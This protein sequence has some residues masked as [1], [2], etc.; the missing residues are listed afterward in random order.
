MSNPETSGWQANSIVPLTYDGVDWFKA[1][2]YNSNTTYNNAL[3]GQGYGVCETAT[4][5]SA[6]VATV[7]GYTKADGGIVTIK[8][9]Q[10]VNANATLN[11]NSLGASP[12]Y[13]RGV[14]IG[15]DAIRAGDTAYFIYN[16]SIYHLL[17]IDRWEGTTYTAGNGIYISPSNQ[18]INEG[19]VAIGQGAENGTIG[20][21]IGNNSSNVAVKGLR[22]LAFQDAI[23]LATTATAG[24]VKVGSGIT[25][26]S[27]GTISM[28][29]IEGNV[30]GDGTSGHLTKFTADNIIGDGPALS[31]AIQTQTTSTKFLREDGTWSVPSYTE[32]T[33]SLVEQKN[34][35]ANAEYRV[36]LSSTANNAN[37]IDIVNKSGGLTFNPHENTLTVA[38][39]N[40]KATAAAEADHAS[41]AAYAASALNATNAENATNAV[42]AQHAATA[43][44]AATAN[45]TKG[46]LS[47]GGKSFNGSTSVSV[48]AADLGISGAMHFLGISSTALIDGS[49]ASSIVVSGNTITPQNGDVVLYNSGEY[50][51]TGTLWELLGDES[52]YKIKQTAVLNPT[53][54]STNSYTF[55]QSITQDEQGVIT[56]VR[57]TVP[58]A[59]TNVAGIVTTGAQTFA[60]AKTFT[61][62][63]TATTFSGYL[64]GT[65]SNALSANYANSA[66]NANTVNNHTV[67]S[68]VPANAVFTDTWVANSVSTAGYVT[69]PGTSNKNKV[70]KTNDSGVPGWRDD[71]NTEY[72]V[73]TATEA[74]GGTATTGRVVT[75]ALLK[76]LSVASAETAGYAACADYA[77]NAGFAA[78]ATNAVEA[79][80]AATAGNAANADKVNGHTVAVDVPANA[81]FTDTWKANAVGSEGYVA[82]TTAGTSNKV[83]KT[84]ASGVPGW[85]DDT[86]T[87]YENASSTTAGLLSPTM[88]SK[89]VGIATAA[90]VGTITSLVAGSG[91]SGGTITS[92]GTISH[93]VAEG[94]SAGA[95]GNTENTRTYIKSVTTDAF[96]HVTAVTTGSETVT[97]TDRYVNS[98]SFADAT[99]TTSGAPLKITLT[100]AGSDSVQVVGNLPVVSPSSPGVAPKGTTVTNQTTATKFLREDGTWAAPSYI[101]NSNTTYTFTNGTNGSFTVQASNATAAQTVTIGK[102]ATAGAADTAGKFASAK[103]VT[104]TGDVTG[105]AS[106]QAGWSIATT[107]A[108]TGVTT[109]SYGQSTTKTASYGDSI[110]IPYITV[111]SK[112]RITSATNS[113][114]TLPS[115]SHYTTKLIVGSNTSTTNLDTNN[116]NTYFRL[117]DDTTNRAT[118]GISGDDATTV[119][120]DANGNIL[121][122]SHDTQT[123]VTWDTAENKLV[124]TY[125]G[126]ASDIVTAATLKTAINVTKSDLG[127]GNVE[128][129]SSATIRSELTSANVTT[130]LGFTPYDAT[131]PNGYTTN[132][133]TVTSV[134][135]QATSPVVSSSSAAQSKTL[136]TT[137]SL[138]DNY[139]DTKNP[140]GSKTKNYVLAAP[141]AAAGAPTFR[142]LVA[143]DIPTLTVSKISDFPSSLTPTSHTHGNLSNDGK[144]TSTVTI[145]NGDKLVI[146]DSD[147][148][149]ASKI[150]GS[151]ITFD[152]STTTKALTQ[153]GTWE[154]FLQSHQDISGKLD[155]T[156]G[157]TNVAWD[158]T[159]KKLTKT[160]NGTTSDVVTISTIK[161]ALNLS[162]SDVG[163]GNVDNTSDVNKPIS[164]ATQTALN[165]KAPLASPALTGTPTAPTAAAGTNTTQ[166]ATTEFV[167]SALSSLI[168][169]MYFVGTLGTGGTATSINEASNS[170][171]G[172]TYKVI[173]AGTYQGVTVE[174]GDMLVSD[175][176]TWVRIPSGDEPV[177]TITN[178]ATGEG[179]T[180]GPI[181]SSG[182]LKHAVPSGAASG[183]KG[184]S[185]EHVYIKTITTDKFGHIT[186]VTTGSEAVYS[187][188]TASSTTKG[189]IKVGTGLTMNGEVLNHS[190]SVTAITAQ[191]STAT[192]A[193]ANGGTIVVRDI[194]YDAQGHVTG[195]NDRTI[196]L[197][198]TTYT[199]SG[200]GG[201]GS[202]TATGTAPLTLNATKSGTTV[203]LTGSVS[204]ATTSAAGLMSAADKAKLDGIAA[205]ANNYSYTLPTASS[206]TKG[207]V[208]VGTTL[209][210]SS[211]V[212]NLATI[213]TSATTSTAAPA[214]GATFTAVDGITTDSYGRVTA[215]NTKTVTLPADN[216][217]DTKVTQSTSTT[218]SW[219]KILLGYNTQANATASSATATNV[220]Y[221][222]DNISVQPSTGTLRATVYNVADKVSLVFNATTNALDFVFA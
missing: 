62:I 26:D 200:L 126:V 137:I 157:V 204:A 196:T 161:T 185:T 167:T 6:K 28:T 215:I 29:P 25:L 35:T 128:N 218:S 60:G 85:R 94:A 132:T 59:T 34:V 198:Q 205:G 175:G 9:N 213:T 181:T 166:I 69:A 130:A 171:K 87:V 82:A 172:N 108:N 99:S 116:G 193:S 61:G 17:G 168:G 1:F 54:S 159:N 160:I 201:V 31:S 169:P 63:V 155:K 120:S 49:T 47:I 76:N 192:T 214:H 209:A 210:I 151:S 71:N 220:I 208:K 152:G 3:L 21:T 180:G 111:D 38:N 149:A 80:H 163:L 146:V 5:L 75:A 72:D 144:I 136:N 182:T 206:T 8:F 222:A 42:E 43:T 53:S 102:P 139:G 45:K 70:W 104:L 73:M 186:A 96:G 158:S 156:T 113:T 153:K 18:I 140:Y 67:A 211:E 64:Y 131:N 216:N 39:I 105:T 147:T 91:L 174:V 58:N 90:Q 202:V 184:S 154:T 189:G 134:R 27:N 78:N 162:K 86:N 68:D 23:P 199:L 55:I 125:D 24:L 46:T 118:I 88:Y 41:S 217:T 112:G 13:H 12:I 115:V 119:S 170:N 148:T 10:K 48:T 92:S 122:T 66:G 150:T 37:L 106:S 164:T 93:A 77:T 2:G 20:V 83:W 109:G 57:G 114:I 194:K 84:N 133:G 95:K 129:K 33:D 44:E 97:N 203:T 179:L 79:V 56:P 89:L 123:S 81:L 65:A 183:E 15:D 142:A 190:N 107:L 178:I 101:E 16:N 177:G 176:T 7:T 197:S 32:N 124:E 188:P 135:V 187:L 22:N 51:W 30:T 100:R 145:G 103:S 4:S 74:S 141:S 219:R 212:L 19:V 121:I 110:V 138:A 40:G 117:F 127:L 191:P 173:T 221:H 52:S 50:V 165:L 11:I 98:I 207:G 195:H 143:D 36:L 14:A